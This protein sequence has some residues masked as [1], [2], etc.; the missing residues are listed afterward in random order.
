MSN[1][2]QE[3]LDKNNSRHVRIFQSPEPSKP[4]ILSWKGSVPKVLDI[5]P[6]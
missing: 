3:I 2:L 1:R 4:Q 5:L 6:D